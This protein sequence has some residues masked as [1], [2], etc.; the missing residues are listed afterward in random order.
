[1]LPDEYALTVKPGRTVILGMSVKIGLR[2][3][4]G[5]AAAYEPQIEILRIPGRLQQSSKVSQRM[6]CSNHYA[7]YHSF[8]LTELGTYAFR[9]RPFWKIPGGELEEIHTMTKEQESNL[10]ELVGLKRD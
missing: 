4:K 6:E 10:R 8:D 2:Y 7:I 9:V 1:M 5:D 3:Q